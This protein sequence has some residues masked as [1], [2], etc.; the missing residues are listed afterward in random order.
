MTIKIMP[1]VTM[2]EWVRNLQKGYRVIGPKPISGQYVFGDIQSASELALDYASSILPPKKILLPQCE[3]LIQF[4][5]SKNQ[6]QIESLFEDRPTVILGLH[7]CDLHAIALLDRAFGSGQ[8]DQHYLTRRKN[9]TIVTIECLQ[10]CSEH[11]FCK[12][13]DTLSTH[14]DFDLHMTDLGDMF[15]IDIGSNSGVNLLWDFAGIRDVNQEDLQRLQRVMSEKW[16]RFPYKLNFDVSELPSLLELSYDS[17]LWDELGEQCLACGICTIVCPTCYCFDVRDE[18]DLTLQYGRRLRVWDSCQ[19]D[20][21][22]MVAGGHNFRA[23]QSARIRHRFFHKGKYQLEAFGI[24]GCVGC[25]RCAQACL[26]N[27]SPIEVFNELHRRRA[28]SARM[29]QELRI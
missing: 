28:P 11:S 4:D 1:K 13:M 25:G 27:I 12:S 23:S 20:P 22:A 9:A 17:E 10:P 6:H 8:P 14:G 26:V 29:K 21:F 18:V 3:P 2:S 16:Q 15:A 19:L 5:T 7:T 24:V